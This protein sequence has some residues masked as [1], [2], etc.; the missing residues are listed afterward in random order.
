[1]RR[2]PAASAD[3][4]PDPPGDRQPVRSRVVTAWD[5]QAPIWSAALQ[6]L[7]AHEPADLLELGSGDRL[8][9]AVPHP[10]DETLGVGGI[11]QR[12]HRSGVHLVLVLATAGRAAYGDTG[13]AAATLGRTRIREF[14][15]AIALLG[16]DRAEVHELDLP[17][18]EL[19]KHEA[20][21]IGALGDLLQIAPLRA[22]SR[23]AVLG[24]W[25]LDPHPDHQAV[26]RAAGIA[27]RRAGALRWSYPI[28]MRPALAPDQPAVPW[29]DIRRV[30]LSPE[31]SKI[32]RA[33]I[34]IY[35]SQLDG[36]SPA[37]EPVLP[38][39]VIDHFTDGQEL[40]IA[41]SPSEADAALHF[42]ALYEGSDDPWEVATSWYELRKRAVLLAS[43]PRPRYE[44]VWEP[45]C[46]LG[47]LSAE[48]ALRCDRLV[49]TDI[50][51]LAIERARASVVAEQ[52]SFAVQQTPI[53]H[54]DLATGSCDLVVLSE[55]LYYLPDSARAATIRLAV[56]LLRPDGHLVVV[57]WRGHPADAH[58][59][60]EQANAEVVTALGRI[61]VHHVDESFVLDITE[62]TGEPE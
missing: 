56:E 62:K 57:H 36:P 7:P 30:P 9:V 19:D 34:E 38:T 1:M 42:E 48:L 12:L 50:S 54:P 32:K 52:V 13:H 20:S 37:V 2:E 25:P 35:K 10:D 33:A 6:A 11:L 61:L 24:P 43:L 45:G 44:C 26:G 40:L 4:Q 41:P 31:E 60:G 47:H 29:R 23:A 21:V 51:P 49:C 55:F 58:C 46:S 17:D 39:H 16:L 28:W 22:G 53:Q 15:D 27:A 14:R 8:V 59:S 3:G 18:G 5:E